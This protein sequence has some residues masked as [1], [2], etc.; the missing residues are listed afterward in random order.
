MPTPNR[1]F[2]RRVVVLAVLSCSIGACDLFANR[3]YFYV[4]PIAQYTRLPSSSRASFFYHSGST[5]SSAGVISYDTTRFSASSDGLGGGLSVGFVWGQNQSFEMGAEGTITRFT[6]S[7]I[8]TQNNPYSSATYSGNMKVENVLASFRHYFGK[9]EAKLRPYYGAVLGN[10]DVS[11]S[12]PAGTP[13][14]SFST[15]LEGNRLTGGLGLGLVYKVAEA[16]QIE[17]GYRIM[18]SER[19]TFMGSSNSSLYEK[20]HTFS[21]SLRQHF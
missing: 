21:F 14:T 9:K 4:R 16:T 13:A 15:A 1:F 6:G 20:S 10:T 12:K 18:Q 17:A 2:L 7:Y 8:I 5:V 3:P 19:I 11:F